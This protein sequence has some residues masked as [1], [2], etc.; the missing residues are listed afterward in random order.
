MFIVNDHEAEQ[1]NNGGKVATLRPIRPSGKGYFKIG[2]LQKV[3][4]GRDFKNG[5]FNRVLIL[6][7][8]PVSIIRLTIKDF[9]ALGYESKAEYLAQDYNQNNPSPIRMRYDF[10]TLTDLA[11]I[12]AGLEIDPDNFFYIWD[13]V[14]GCKELTAGVNPDLIFEGCDCEDLESEFSTLE[15]NIQEARL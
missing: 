2:S 15:S 12:M 10:I 14:K 11:E 1:I 13:I 5:I 9:V 3:C 7:R 8:Y 6:N 4:R